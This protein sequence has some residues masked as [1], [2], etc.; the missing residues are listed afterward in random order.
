MKIQISQSHQWKFRIY[1]S[2]QWRRLFNTPFQ[3][4]RWRFR[5][6]HACLHTSIITVFDRCVN[7]L[8][9][10]HQIFPRPRF[11]FK[12]AIRTDVGYMCTVDVSKDTK[13]TKNVLNVMIS[14]GKASP[15]CA[16]H[17]WHTRAY[18][19]CRESSPIMASTNLSIQVLHGSGWM[20]NATCCCWFC[21]CFSCPLPLSVSGTIAFASFTGFGAFVG[22]SMVS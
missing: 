22:I 14:S 21:C 3:Q 4:G 20:T 13:W 10:D 1:Y 11:V 18:R 16:W 9:V 12:V 7:I 17:R 15:L 6:F 5:L 19:W 8:P 2:H